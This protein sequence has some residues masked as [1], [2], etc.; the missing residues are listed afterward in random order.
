MS[1]SK[2]PLILLEELKQT[3]ASR[4]PN[5]RSAENVDVPALEAELR[6]NIEGEVRFDAGSRA[7]Y[8]VDGS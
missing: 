7:M 5:W 4:P 3:I 2:V 8:A 6:K 1:A